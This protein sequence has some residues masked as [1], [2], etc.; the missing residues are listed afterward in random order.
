MI[1]SNN[2][3][4]SK[5]NRFCRQTCHDNLRELNHFSATVHPNLMAGSYR[6][7]EFIK[8]R[9][10]VYVYRYRVLQRGIKQH[11]FLI[12]SQKCTFLEKLL[13]TFFKFGWSIIHTRQWACDGHMIEVNSKRASVK[14]MAADFDDWYCYSC[15]LLTGGVLNCAEVA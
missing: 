9:Y 15:Y 12:S 4:N 14:D 13:R 7:T 1:R 8:T 2:T 6:W 3:S 5:T 10:F 11:I